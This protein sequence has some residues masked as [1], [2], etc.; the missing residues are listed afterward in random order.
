MRKLFV[1]LLLCCVVTTEASD[2]YFPAGAN[3]GGL[4]HASVG[5]LNFWSAINNPAAS[6]FLSQVEIGVNYESRFNLDE[7]SVKTIALA[8]PN[9]FGTITSSFQ[10]F[11]YEVY[12]EFR[13]A[14]G[15]ARKFGSNLGAS[16][17]F[18]ALGSRINPEIPTLYAFTFDASVYAKLSETLG[19]GFYVFNLPAS[20]F[21]STE[22]NVEIPVLYRLGGEWM[23]SNKLSVLGEVRGKNG[24]DPSFCGGT[25]YELL[26][27]FEVSVGLANN[28]FALT[29]GMQYAKWG[30]TMGVSCAVIRQIGKVWNCSLAYGF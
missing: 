25:N 27:G 12:N 14:L 28:P 17:Q 20:Q 4:A 9:R 6:S 29:A 16:V 24:E 23:L 8:Y 26:D 15:F 19:L 21:K 13:Y 2:F 7:L 10:Y 22:Q 18:C 1:F 3:S 5:D 11:G 30:V